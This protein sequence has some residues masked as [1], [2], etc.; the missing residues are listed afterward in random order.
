MG[1]PRPKGTITNTQTQ[2]LLFPE[3]KAQLW[4]GCSISGFQATKAHQDMPQPLTNLQN[5][6]PGDPMKSMVFLTFSWS[7]SSVHGHHPYFL[8]LDGA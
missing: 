6:P 7:I 2:L 4:S 3:T 8:H 1:Y 5:S